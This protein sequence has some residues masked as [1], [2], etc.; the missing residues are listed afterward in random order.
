[1][2]IVPFS[3]KTEFFLIHSLLKEKSEWPRVISHLA[4]WRHRGKMPA[5][6]D[7]T[8]SLL[9]ALS[10]PPKPEYQYRLVLSMA[11][12]RFVNSAVDPF[13]KGTFAQ[14]I[15]SIA[16]QIGLPGWFVDL[17]H[18][19]THDHLPSLP[20]LL[21]GCYQ[22]LDW[23]MENYWD[24]I[25]IEE[26]CSVKDLVNEYV[27]HKK[28]RNLI[29]DLVSCDQSDLSRQLSKVLLQ[30]G[31]LV[32]ASK[33][34][35]CSNNQ[36]K[37]PV[38]LLEL[39]MPLFQELHE[40]DDLFIPFLFG[41]LMSKIAEEASVSIK[42][43]L[44]F[45]HLNLGSWARTLLQK[46]SS[47]SN[48]LRFIRSCL[49]YPASPLSLELLIIIAN[50]NL[51][52]SP[53]ELDVFISYMKTMQHKSGPL[54][55]IQIDLDTLENRVL[56]LNQNIRLCGRWALDSNFVPCPLGLSSG[57]LSLN[58]PTESGSRNE[59]KECR[60]LNPSL[61]SEATLPKKIQFL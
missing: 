59:F 7:S 24:V 2:H 9:E 13:Q 4:N 17:R 33:A 58:K 10:S 22:A 1:M 36:P 34:K 44:G 54:E 55:P 20:I 11:F 14:S 38:E 27:N 30:K 39:W 51:Y 57:D 46:F 3:N 52:D 41:D 40:N 19:A 6:A 35:R 5:S 48:I 18:A 43:T 8:C 15:Q 42:I 56:E 16:D 53:R 37:L 21:N 23:I 26:T 49:L 29:A 60:V 31:Y 12:I 25:G 50:G 61:F 47:R 32:P 28:A 45:S